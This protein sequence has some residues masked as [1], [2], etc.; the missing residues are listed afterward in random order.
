MAPYSRYIYYVLKVYTLLNLFK[1]KVFLSLSE[2]RSKFQGTKPI[3]C[4]VYTC[5]KM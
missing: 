4:T 2:T 1:K 3:K 5:S